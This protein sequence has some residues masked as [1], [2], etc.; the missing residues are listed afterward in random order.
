MPT[1]R[2]TLNQTVSDSAPGVPGSIPSR[3]AFPRR[4]RWSA[5]RVI[6]VQ[7]FGD[8]F[9]LEIIPVNSVLLGAAH[10]SLSV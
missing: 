5:R 4:E 6:S 2:Q 7:S 3:R 1:G 9:L 8:A 10:R